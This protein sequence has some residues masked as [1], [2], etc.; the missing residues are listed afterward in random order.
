MCELSY[1]DNN[2]LAMQF[3]LKANENPA[4]IGQKLALIPYQYFQRA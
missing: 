1:P 4:Q 3:S 2:H